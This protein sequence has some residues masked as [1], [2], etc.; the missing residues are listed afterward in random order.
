MKIELPIEL[1]TA[2]IRYLS[3]QPYEDVANMIQ[4]MLQAGTHQAAQQT[5]S[6]DVNKPLEH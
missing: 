1:A 6:R 2:I 5:A 3:R 4:G